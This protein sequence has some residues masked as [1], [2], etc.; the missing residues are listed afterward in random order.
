MTIFSSFDVILFQ[1]SHFNIAAP[2]VGFLTSQFVLLLSFFSFNQLDFRPF[3]S[4]LR[5]IESLTN[6]WAKFSSSDMSA[7]FWQ[8]DTFHLL[9]SSA[10]SPLTLHTELSFYFLFAVYFSHFQGTEF[11]RHSVW[12]ST[13]PA[14][15]S[16]P[17]F[18]LL[19]II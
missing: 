1:L 10:L 9:S 14:A 19:F 8:Q 16:L 7:A 6:S 12:V 17:F 13:P 4:T 5:A 2:L 18:F 3:T 15:L 11:S